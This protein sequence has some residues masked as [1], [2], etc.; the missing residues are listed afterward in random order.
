M[1]IKISMPDVVSI[2]K[3]IQVARLNYDS[4]A[5]IYQ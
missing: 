4:K 2:F 1:R 3:E 5:N